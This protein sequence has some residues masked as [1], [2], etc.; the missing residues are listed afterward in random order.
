MTALSIYDLRLMI[1]DLKKIPR[2][3]CLQ[4]PIVN[5]KS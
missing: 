3:A 2:N 1:D 5:R 4:A